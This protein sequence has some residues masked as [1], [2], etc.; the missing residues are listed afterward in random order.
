MKKL[1]LVFLAF[2]S[3]AFAGLKIHATTLPTGSW[4]RLGT[5]QN[6]RA[7]SLI[8]KSCPRGTTAALYMEYEQSLLAVRCIPEFMMESYKSK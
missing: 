3:F 8:E 5:I 7:Y 6:Q 4:K 1:I 2:V